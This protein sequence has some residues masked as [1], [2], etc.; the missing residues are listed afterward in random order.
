LVCFTK[1][2][3][4]FQE[5]K[6]TDWIPANGSKGSNGMVM[7]TEDQRVKEFLQGMERLNESDRHYIDSLTRLLVHMENS[8]L[9]P[10]STGIPVETQK[11]V[12]PGSCGN[13]RL[14][15]ETSR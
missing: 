7:I 15:A 10:D 3:L 1:V 12:S 6:S 5:V 9:P 2:D 8:A 11:T 14:D 13:F 4:F